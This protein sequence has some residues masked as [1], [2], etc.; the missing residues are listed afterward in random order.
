[1]A[2]MYLHLR[3]AFRFDQ[4]IDD[5]DDDYLMAIEGASAALIAPDNGT[6]DDTIMDTYNRLGLA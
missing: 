6:L 5:L 1:M 4:P 2:L 3:P